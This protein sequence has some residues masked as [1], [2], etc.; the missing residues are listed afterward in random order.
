MKMEVETIKNTA[1]KYF[2]TEQPVT[3]L[4]EW[5]SEEFACLKKKKV[6]VVGCLDT[7]KISAGWKII[8]KKKTKG[9]LKEILCK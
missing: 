9:I 2:C 4:G 5:I 3:V 6:S 7:K 8:K 1:K